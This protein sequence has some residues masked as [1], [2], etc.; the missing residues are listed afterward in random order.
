MRA[1]SELGGNAL[2]QFSQVGLSSSMRLPSRGSC[3]REEPHCCNQFSNDFVDCSDFNRSI[4]N[5]PHTLVI[6]DPIAEHHAVHD[7]RAKV[8]QIESL[9]GIELGE[10]RFAA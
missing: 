5:A 8:G 3:R 9:C 4:A 1:S 7:L 2:L 6:D 10:L